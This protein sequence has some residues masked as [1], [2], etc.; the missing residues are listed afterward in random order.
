MKM[1]IL[2]LTSVVVAFVLGCALTY[3]RREVSGVFIENPTNATL[4]AESCVRHY[5]QP[6]IRITVAE[7]PV[8]KPPV[9]QHV[10]I[11]EPHFMATP[12]PVRP[13]EVRPKEVRPKEVGLQTRWSIYLPPSDPKRP[14]SQWARGDGFDDESSC[15]RYKGKMLDELDHSQSEDSTV[16]LK[17]WTLARC[18]EEQ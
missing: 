9:V 17:A 11:Y 14:L 6:C 18:I 15:E 13:K 1:K 16:L 12:P 3:N 10:A 8:I 7:A 2:W 4:D 5:D